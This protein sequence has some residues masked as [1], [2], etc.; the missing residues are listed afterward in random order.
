MTSSFEAMLPRD[1]CAA[2]LARRLL[3]ERYGIVLDP[4]QLDTAKLLVSELVNNAVVHGRGE[5]TLKTE[6]DAQRLRVD[7]VDEGGGFEHEIRQVGFDAV[8]GRGLGIVDTG[9]SRWGV[10][11]GTTRVWFELDRS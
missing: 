8:G 9:A 7:V 6:V 1:P 10:F 4:E 5:I 11:G 2:R 3:R